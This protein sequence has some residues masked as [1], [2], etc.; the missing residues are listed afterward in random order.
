MEIVIIGAGKVG[1]EIVEN[2]VAENHNI[3]VVD[4]DASAL[5]HLMNEV[6]VMSVC[7]NGVLESIQTEAGVPKC[8]LV[9]AV[10]EHD[11]TNII[12]CLVAKAIGAKRTIA[13]VRDTDMSAQSEFM[14][15][16]LGIDLMV[17]PELE[18]AEEIS[19][20]LRYPSADDVDCL[21]RGKI[22]LVA[23]KIGLD[24]PIVGLQVKDLLEKVKVK[25]LICMIARGREIIIPDGSTVFEPGDIIHF[26]GAPQSIDAF[27]KK[28]GLSGNR[29]HSMIIVG[30]GRIAY[31]LAKS[32]FETGIKVKI[33][34]KDEQVCLQLADQ[35]P[36]AT[37]VCGDGTDRNLLKQEGVEIVDSFVALTGN[38]EE[39]IV[40]SLYAKSIG[41]GKV[42]AKS[43]NDSYADMLPMLN[44]G[45]IISPK[46]VTS[47]QI[48]KLTRAMQAPEDDSVISLY[49]LANDRAEAITFGVSD[50]ENFVGKTIRDLHFKPGL[51]LTA[52]IRGR[53]LVIPDGG[54]EIQADDIALVISANYKFTKLDDILD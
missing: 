39:N 28:M 51:L 42:I 46:T 40:L 5:K 43:N 22:D 21:N 36:K 7:G 9:L 53:E 2:L 20:M 11:E 18:S 34:E 49:K 16:K 48:I 35:L 23:L 10:T 29:V 47:E 52:I 4:T 50:N 13:R 26:T 38:D 41:V 37:I 6:D 8:D 14:S 30:G 17:N 27:F 45:T 15:K 3:V 12:C 31:Y 24:S 32:L 25:V 19:R 1:A 33:I 54:T 44:L